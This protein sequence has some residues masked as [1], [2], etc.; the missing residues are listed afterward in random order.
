MSRKKDSRFTFGFYDFLRYSSE[1]GR[2]EENGMNVG[3]N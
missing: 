2:N 1:I 3:I